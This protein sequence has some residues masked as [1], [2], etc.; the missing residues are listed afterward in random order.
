MFRATNN[1]EY[2]NEESVLKVLRQLKNKRAAPVLLSMV[3]ARG[4]PYSYRPNFYEDSLLAQT[5]AATGE[6]R[7]I[8]MLCELLQRPDSHVWSS[9]I[10]NKTLV[11]FSDR[12]NVLYALL[13]LTGQVSQDY[14]LM[15]HEQGEGQTMIGFPNPEARKAAVE[16]FQLWWR[17]HQDQPPYKNLIPLAVPIPN[18]SNSPYR[19]GM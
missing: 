18:P 2:V 16:K 10:D 13:M 14:K 7:A 8:P 3:V 6:T 4:D 1:G 15:V 11:S 17:E 19:P 5:L 9:Q 12:D